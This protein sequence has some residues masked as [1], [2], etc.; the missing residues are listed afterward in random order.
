MTGNI[1]L[2]P[3]FA[4]LAGVTPPA[5]VDGRSFADLLHD[6]AVASQPRHAYLLEHDIDN[7]GGV[8]G[9]DVAGTVQV[10]G[11]NSIPAYHGVRTDRFMYVEYSPQQRELYAT[12]RDPYEMHN[13]VYDPHYTNLVNRLHTLVVKLRKCRAAT[14]RT[15]ED[16]P[17]VGPRGLNPR[18]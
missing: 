10:A 8:K 14:C 18:P 12:Q 7:T 17:V 1:D 5:F 13:L 15:L 2:A 9:K 4:Q 3:T 16:T 11:P 6:P